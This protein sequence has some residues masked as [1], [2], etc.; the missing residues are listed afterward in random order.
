MSC[1][2]ICLIGIVAISI[3]SGCATQEM[4]ADS[5]KSRDISQL[6]C[7]QL[8]FMAD[9]YTSI[10]DSAASAGRRGTTPAASASEITAMR[11]Y[12]KADQ[13]EPPHANLAV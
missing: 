3:L 9:K 12:N 7:S 2:P 11:A 6:S 10:G 4:D 5:L 13:F 8:K 1:K